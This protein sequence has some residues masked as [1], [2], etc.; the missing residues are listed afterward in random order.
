MVFLIDGLDES[1]TSIKDEIY[2]DSIVSVLSNLEAL[3][4][5]YFIITTRDYE[6]IL[7]KFKEN[8]LI[9]NILTKEFIKNIDDDVS[10]FIKLNFNKNLISESDENNLDIERIVDQLTE[11]AQGNFLYI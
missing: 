11:K 7:N 8:S 9:L 10:S 3:E 1:I 6:N 4:N 2:S 5:V